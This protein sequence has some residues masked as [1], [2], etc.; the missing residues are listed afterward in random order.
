MK[1]SA[2]D[3]RAT[4]FNVDTNWFKQR[5][6]DQLLSGRKLAKIMKM[7]A[8]ALSLMLNGKRSMSAAEAAELARHLLV[9]VEEVM[10][11]AGIEMKKASGAGGHVAV[12]GWVG[13]DGVVH[14]AGALGPSAVSFPTEAPAGLQALRAQG[15]GRMDGWVFVHRP[16]EGVPLEAVGRLCV[17]QL[18]GES[19]PRLAWVHRGYERGWWNLGSFDGSGELKAARLVSASPILWMLQ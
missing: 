14:S 5:I 17:V 8:S 7:D 4:E 9:P 6:S 19:E 15:G 16:G 3:S 10:R 18:V 13:A 1:S 11:R 12:A 2:Q